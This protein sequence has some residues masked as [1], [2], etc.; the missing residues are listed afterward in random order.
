MG[1]NLQTFPI[2]FKGGLISNMTPLALGAQAIGAATILQNFEPDKEGGYSK[3]KGYAKYSSTAVPGAG[4]ILGLKVVSSGRVIASRKVDAAAV[5]ALQTVTANVNGA[6]SS[7]ANV[8]VDGNSGTIA[9]GQT[10]T[11]TGISTTVKVQTVTNQNNIVLDTAVNL[12]NDVALTFG[13][14][15]TADLNKTAYYYSTGTTWTYLHHG[16]STN[17]EKSRHASFNFTGDEKTV[18][19]DGK[20]F[21]VAYNKSGNTMSEIT[22]STD[23]QAASSV[24]IFKNTAFY[25]KDNNIFF[26]APFT[27]D[28]FDVADGAGSLGVGFDVTGMVVFREQLIIFTTNT[29]KRLVGTTAADF[30][31]EPITEKIGCI[32]G[33]SIQEVGGDVLYLSPDGI[34][35]LG[36]TDRIG[37]FALDVASDNI[38]K[39]AQD[40]LSFSNEFCS[41]TIKNKAQYRIFAYVDSQQ[42]A[43]AKGL[44][45]TKFSAQGAGGISWATIK[46]IKAKVAD[47]IY[48]GDTESIMFG[49]DAGF[50]YVMDS[51]SSLDGSDIESIYE[52]PYM[53]I[54]DSQTRK[55]L[56]KSTF[57]IQPTGTM[58]MELRLKFDYDQRSF[59]GVIQPNAVTISTSGSGLAVFGGAT[60]GGSQTYGAI[61]DT[62]Y[63]TN[64]VGSFKTVAMRITDTSTN[65]TFTLDTAV[66]EFRQN[67]RQ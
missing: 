6:V 43:S 41:V 37:D 33:D 13:T 58:S 23:A 26:T 45:A 34:R 20:N 39:D 5:T 57:Y 24:A 30:R 18:F 42:S 7:S 36:S 40:F 31:L 60:F 22:G 47:S 17:T 3:M 1:T 62:V 55:T 14:I 16:A 56:Y 4:S 29:I 32:N 59:T 48:T 54:T 2:Q 52:T 35:F 63:P 25:A 46:G 28:D 12:S 67:D 53:P 19:V 61:L 27:V 8:A 38:F 50:V 15:G 66:L 11:G 44:I 51:G 21:P 65:P 9:V 49:N 64:L 10:V